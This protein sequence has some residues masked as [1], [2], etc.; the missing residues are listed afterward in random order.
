LALFGRVIMDVRQGVTPRRFHAPGLHRALRRQNEMP[1]ATPFL[2]YFIATWADVGSRHQPLH[3]DLHRVARASLS[4]QGRRRQRPV[5]QRAHTAQG[6]LRHGPGAGAPS[7]RRNGY[8]F[9]HVLV[10]E[11]LLGRHLLPGETVHH[12]NGLRDDNR[13]ENLELWTR[14]QPAGIRA[15][16]AVS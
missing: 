12:L 11:E 10:M 9:E 4:S 14:L 13:P 16:D 5:A 8:V 15:T 3:R 7:R 1:G 6:G 2:D